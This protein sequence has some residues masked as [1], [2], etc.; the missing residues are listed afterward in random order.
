LVL[1]TPSLDAAG[2]VVASVAAGAA[3]AAGAP[4]QATIINTTIINTILRNKCFIKPILSSKNQKN[5]Y[6]YITTL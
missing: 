3:G 1:S 4:P 5:V 6:T 2:A